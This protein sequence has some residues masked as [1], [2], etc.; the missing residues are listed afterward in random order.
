[1]RLLLL[2]IVLIP[3]GLRAQGTVSNISV[4]K[5]KLILELLEA[6]GGKS[7][8]DSMFS[9]MATLIKRNYPSLPDTFIV[10][11]KREFLK[12]NFIEQL[13]PV[14]DHNYTEQELVELNA[15]FKTAIGK[16]MISVMPKVQRESMLIG[17]K[18]GR[19][20]GQKAIEN[21]KGKVDLH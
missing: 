20:A 17:E 21:L 1:M 10:E 8:I 12:S 7:Q 3:L 9:N 14:Y 4:T 13:M 2:A 18:I 11:F 5:R 19:E 15:I 6:T 16:K